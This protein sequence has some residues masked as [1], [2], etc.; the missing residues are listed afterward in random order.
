M[1][2]SLLKNNYVV[3]PNFIDPERAIELSNQFDLDHEKNNYPGD[4]QAP[5]SACAYNYSPAYNLLLESADKVS[6]A[7]GTKVLP[8]YSYSRIYANS[9]VLE[10][11]IDRP[12]CEVSV[13]VNLNLDHPWPIYIED[14]RGNPQEV[15]LNPGDA[16]VF[17]G[18]FVSHWRDK[19][20]GQKYHA[21]FL[22]Y[23]RENGCCA[24]F[25]HDKNRL[26]KDQEE[27]YITKLKQEYRQ[28]GWDPLS[29]DLR[30]YIV[31]F[32]DILDADTCDMIV[33]RYSQSKLWKPAITKE[34]EDNKT[35]V[36]QKRVCDSI[37]ISEHQDQRDVDNI[38][39]EAFNKVV[40]KYKDKYPFFDVQ[41]DEGY[42]LLRYLSGGKYIQHIDAGFENHRTVTAIIALNDDYEGGELKFLDGRHSIRLK[43]GSAII[44]PSTFVF[45]HQIVPV[46][47]GK[48]YSVVTWFR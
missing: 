46:K 33:N 26:A 41:N 10:K 40:L 5:R 3:L 22:H 11:H 4:P 8:T 12:A 37:L 29:F 28:M 7:L 27:P 43:K 42:F 44:F 9:E 19:F 48:R 23:V 16:V 13:S 36:S 39:Y 15:N 25:E 45:P 2:E 18:C 32:E 21:F 35:T 1:N 31:S 34:E 17:L 38:L 14:N 20:E 47:S 24:M 30:D 6:D